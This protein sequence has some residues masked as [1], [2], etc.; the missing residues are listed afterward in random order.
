MET[1]DTFSVLESEDRP[2]THEPDTPG[3]DPREALASIQAARSQVVKS[4]D[5]PF[6]YDIAYG[7]VCGLLVAGQGMPNPWSALVLVVSLVG[8]ALMVTWWRK[9]AGWW[10]NGYSPKRARWVAIGLA[11]FLLGLIGV[12]LYG[13]IYGPWWLF[14]VTGGVAAVTAAVAGR[15]WMRVWRK[16]MSEAVK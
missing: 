12:S 3:Q 14:L 4:A 15:L 2:M 9:K 16:E 1:D 8:L 7:L 10:V 5:Y 6:G 11:A 13:R